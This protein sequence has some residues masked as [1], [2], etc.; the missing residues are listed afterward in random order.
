[1]TFTLGVLTKPDTLQSGEEQAWLDVLDGKR[2]ILK[3]GYYVTKQPAVADLVKK[4]DHEEVREMEQDFFATTPPWSSVA[5]TIR[6]RMGV[7]NL[8]KELSRLLSQLI[9]QT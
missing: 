3:H 8:T 9:E 5:V 2:H 6:N 7:T 4:L 1:M